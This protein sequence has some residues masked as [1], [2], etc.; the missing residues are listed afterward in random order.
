MC[1][2]YAADGRWPAHPADFE[3]RSRSFMDAAHN[4]G[5]RIL[6]LLEPKACPNNAPGTLADSHA[7]WWGCTQVESS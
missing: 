6:T 1:T 7:L 4:L 2:P 5:S 3:R